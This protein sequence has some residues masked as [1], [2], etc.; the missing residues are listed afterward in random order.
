MKPSELKLLIKEVIQTINEMVGEKPEIGQY[1]WN[2][3]IDIIVKS[4]DG[5]E[6]ERK[7]TSKWAP[8]LAKD[9]IE[10]KELAVAPYNPRVVTIKKV[11]M[12]RGNP[13]TQSDIEQYDKAVAGYA[14]A[15]R[16]KSQGGWG[17]NEGVK[18]LTE[19]V[20]KENTSNISPEQKKFADDVIN[21]MENKTRDRE[22]TWQDIESMRTILKFKLAQEGWRKGSGG[23]GSSHQDFLAATRR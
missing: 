19:G 5:T 17:A 13:I 22:P 23:E 4:P 10:A 15:M 18:K 14:H 11:R 9:E 3:E 8:I 1:H 21:A 20:I 12:I 7:D 16:P 6:Y 2:Y